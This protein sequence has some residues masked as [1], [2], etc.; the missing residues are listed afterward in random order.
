MKFFNNITQIKD[1]ILQEGN[2]R[3]GWRPTRKFLVYFFLFLCSWTFFFTYY[4]CYRLLEARLAETVNRGAAQ[5]ILVDSPVLEGIIPSLSVREISFDTDAGQLSLNDVSID[6]HLFPLYASVSCRLAGG[7]AKIRLEP[8][9]IFSPFPMRAYGDLSNTSLPELMTGI[10]RE[11]PVTVTAGNIALH[12]DVSVARVPRNARDLSGTI[13]LSLSEGRMRHGLPVLRGEE[14]THIKGRAE[15][16]L[17]ADRMRIERLSVE[18]EGI[19]LEADGI[20]RLVGQP[21]RTGLDIRA[22]LILAPERVS[23]DLLPKRTRR[24]IEIN[25]K[26]LVRIGGTLA[27]PSPSLMEQ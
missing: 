2:V 23:L 22:T 21:A 10:R 24:Q 17:S 15:M 18:S 9:S 7:T 14:L 26:I 6:L 4:Y 13:I 16:T 11:L 12:L 19:A 20:L 1:F 25:G 27:S 5:G 8:E 3:R